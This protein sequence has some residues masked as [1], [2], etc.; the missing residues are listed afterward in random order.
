VET[1]F[2]DPTFAKIE[3]LAQ[4]IQDLQQQGARLVFSNVQKREALA[5]KLVQKQKALDLAELANRRESGKA[6]DPSPKIA[7]LN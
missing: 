7:K 1:R 6:S 3:E 4:Q 2:E 5:M